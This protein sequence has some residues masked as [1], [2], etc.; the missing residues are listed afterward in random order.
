M[1][2]YRCPNCQQKL[3]VPDEYEGRRIR[4]SKCAQPSVVP[5]RIIPV[6]RPV[7]NAAGPVPVAAVVK[8]APAPAQPQ[9]AV[10]TAAPVV[11]MPRPAAPP[12]QPQVKA[13]P[14]PASAPGQSVTIIPDVP[15]LVPEEEPPQDLQEDPNA[16]ILR[17]YRNARARKIDMKIPAGRAGRSGRSKPEKTSK[18]DQSEEKGG[19]SLGA[20][21]P[22]ALRTPLAFILA[23]GLVGGLILTWVAVARTSDSSMSFFAAL[24]PLA[25][26]AALRL[27]P[28]RGTAVGFLAVILGIVGIGAGKAA[29][30]KWGMIP[31]FEKRAHEEVLENLPALLSDKNLQIPTDQSAKHILK[32]WD[33]LMCVALAHLVDQKEADPKE[34]RALALEMF[35]LSGSG[36]GFTEAVSMIGANDASVDSRQEA[37]AERMKDNKLYNKATELIFGWE[38]SDALKMA[39]QYY[40]AYAKL[41]SQAQLIHNLQNS[42]DLFKFA[43]IASL[44]ALDMIWIALGIG[45][46]FVITGLD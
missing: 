7:Q 5:R 30:A 21:L 6:A 1:I 45:G 39:R 22:D 13:A 32:R 43:F 16:A 31:M 38:D 46:A 4:C 15:E 20:L 14:Q 37:F 10:P 42:D 23:F 27:I 8:A 41:M 11:S 35:D 34:A 3:G 36:T 29:M 33:C 25:G 26:A 12:P 28:Q 24:I 9:S 44:S 17:D 19:F 40:P 2:K 18:D